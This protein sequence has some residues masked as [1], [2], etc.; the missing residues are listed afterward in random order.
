MQA[1]NV[2]SGENQTIYAHF[3]FETAKQMTEEKGLLDSG[4]TH[5]FIDICTIIRLEIGTRRLK[6]PRTVTNVDRTTNRAGSIIWYANLRF[7]YQNK[8]KDLPVYITNLGRDRII[9]ELPW[10]QHFE[11]TIS[12]KQGILKGEM[13]VKTTNA[14]MQIN[15]ATM[16]TTWAIEHEGEKVRLKEKDVPK[17]YQEFVDV[18]SEEKAKH[19]SHSREE[20]HEIEFTENVPKF[21]KPNVQYIRCP[22]NKQPSSENG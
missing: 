20:D 13:K 2:T 9:L 5:N 6:K 12:W 16:A 1:H 4:A 22:P 8:E 21:V 15:K 14:V 19:F 3:P 11:P 17:H 10:F 18:F 7:T